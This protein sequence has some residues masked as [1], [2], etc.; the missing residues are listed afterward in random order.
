MA[1]LHQ[2]REGR[3][4]SLTVAPEP[5]A[6]LCQDLLDYCSKVFVYSLQQMCMSTHEN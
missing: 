1:H 3:A 4:C 5:A 6:H 2:V